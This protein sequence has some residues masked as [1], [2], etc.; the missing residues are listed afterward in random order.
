MMNDP[1]KK[2]FEDCLDY[3]SKSKQ[4]VNQTSNEY[5]LEMTEQADLD[6]DATSTK[7]KAKAFE[8]GVKSILK[9]YNDDRLLVKEKQKI[10]LA[11]KHNPQS[12]HELGEV[13][14]IF[15]AKA[16]LDKALNLNL[17]YMMRIRYENGPKILINDDYELIIEVKSTLFVQADDNDKI[18]KIWNQALLKVGPTDYQKSV[19]KLIIELGELL[20]K[21]MTISQYTGHRT[22]QIMFVYNG[23]INLDLD[24]LFGNKDLDQDKM[25]ESIETKINA[26][27]G[28]EYKVNLKVIWTKIDAP[29]PILC[30]IL[31]DKNRD[32]EEL[33]KT[34]AKLV[35]VSWLIFI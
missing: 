7:R 18:M 31:D 32:I 23:G 24:Q 29:I 12:V 8:D 30:K 10:M 6:P 25:T 2:I 33:K 5:L 34:Q 22:L 14:A 4:W 13:D 19:M 17:P 27:F 3:F 35:R 21:S 1:R 11:N 28:K 16:G 9:Y 26:L 15:Q 20:S